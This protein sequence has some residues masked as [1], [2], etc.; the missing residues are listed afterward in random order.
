MTKG[1]VPLRS[2][3]VRITTYSAGLDLELKPEETDGN[4]MQLCINRPEILWE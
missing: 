3:N 2:Y 1:D 4:N